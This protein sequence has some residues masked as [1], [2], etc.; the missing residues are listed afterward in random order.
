MD[1][2]RT[3]P[4]TIVRKQTTMLIGNSTYSIKGQDHS[5]YWQSTTQD[6][7]AIWVVDG[8]YPLGNESADDVETLATDIS[9]H[10]LTAYESDGLQNARTILRTVISKLPP[11]KATATLTLAQSNGE[12]L[13][14][15]DSEA[16]L[17]NGHRIMSPEFSGVEEL[18]M[19]RIKEK[20]DAGWD[21]HDA[22]YSVH[23]TLVDRR[24][25]R[26]KL[27]NSSGWIMGEENRYFI[28]SQ[29]HVT[30]FDPRNGAIVITDGFSRVLDWGLEES[31]FDMVKEEKTDNT[32]TQL[33]QV[34]QADPLKTQ[35]LR[36]SVSDDA[37]IAWY[38]PDA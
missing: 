14:L 7:W 3:R 25:R 26:N 2:F 18:I 38:L 24:E 23:D 15:G 21:E 8:A 11:M 17:S 37:S 16:I 34:E 33:R 6:E 32:I 1:T 22:Y 12:I 28:P 30:S 31:L 13:T 35:H 20:L 4:L 19:S 29:A 10:F 36:F 5:G 27:N 9:N